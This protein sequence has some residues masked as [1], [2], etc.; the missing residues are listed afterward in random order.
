M[1]YFGVIGVASIVLGLALMALS[2]KIQ[3]YMK[4]IR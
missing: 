4:G 3:G 1:A 2:P